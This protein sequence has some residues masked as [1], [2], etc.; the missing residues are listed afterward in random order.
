MYGIQ[1]NRL[2]WLTMAFFLPCISTRTIS[3]HS[4]S[5]E[6]IFSHVHY[7][8]NAISCLHILEGGIDAG[9]RL[10]MSNKLVNLELATHVIVHQIREL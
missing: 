4:R 9:Q 6:S 7:T 3:L 2:G 10:A 8:A 1:S 5:Y